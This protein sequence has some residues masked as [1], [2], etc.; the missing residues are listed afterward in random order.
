MRTSIIFT[1]IFFALF[2]IKVHTTQAQCLKSDSLELIKLYN[3]T[4]GANWKHKWGL[5]KPVS[6]WYG[7]TLT[8]DGCSV[9]I[10]E[11]YR[12]R[13]SGHIPNLDLPKLE[14]LYLYSNELSG[15]IPNFDLPKLEK[16]YL[17]SNKLSGSIP[18]FDLPK[19]EKLYLYSNQLSGQLPNFDLPE[20]KRLSLSDNQLS[21]QLPNFDLPKLEELYLTINKLNGSIPDFDLPKLEVLN[22]DINELSGSIPDFDL[23]KLEV[24]YLDYNELS[25]PIP[26]FDH[27]T[28]LRY[29]Y[30]NNNQLS[31]PIP[32]FDLPNLQDLKLSNNQLSG[33]IPDFNLPNLQRLY[34]DNNELSGSIPGFNLPNLT[35]LDLSHNRLSG[36]LP[37]FKDFLPSRFYTDCMSNYCSVSILN[38]SYNAF[39][40]EGIEQNLNIYNI[41]YENQ[42]TIPIYKNEK[43]NLYVKAGGDIKKNS[44]TWYRDGQKYKTIVGDSLFVPTESGTYYCEVRNCVITRKPKYCTYPYYYPCKT[45][46]SEQNLILRSDEIS[47]R[48]SSNSYAQEGLENKQPNNIILFPNPAKESVSIRLEEA[49]GKRVDIQVLDRFGGVHMKRSILFT[50]ETIKLNVRSL[51]D[52]YYYVRIQVEGKLVVTKPLIIRLYTPSSIKPEF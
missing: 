10:I 37:D 11:L 17:S 16:L 12:R 49:K 19:L 1:G 33:P 9:K 24:L 39:T 27:L 45:K 43:N 26:D 25:G 51:S 48:I 41:F 13:L 18:D 30:S 50:D 44:Y 32:N 38:L 4:N 34:L 46:N 21:G 3:A 8:D 28:N 22:L 6:A 2:T 14:G 36:A 20:L 40:F 5:K 23:P 7:I 29:I 35:K 42:D 47:V 15:S 31:G 52:G